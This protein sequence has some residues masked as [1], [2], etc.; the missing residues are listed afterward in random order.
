M[1][2]RRVETGYH[3][4]LTTELCGAIIELLQA[5]RDFDITELQMY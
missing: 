2:Q 4:F 1:M 5:P 3:R